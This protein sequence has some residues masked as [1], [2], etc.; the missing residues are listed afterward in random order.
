VGFTEYRVALFAAY[1]AVVVWKYSKHT[2][3]NLWI[4]LIGWFVLRFLIWV[5]E[6]GQ[7]RWRERQAVRAVR[8][9]DPAHQEAL[10]SKM[11]LSVDRRF[12]RKRLAAEGTPERADAVERFFF[13]ASDHRENVLLFWVTA[14]V[15]MGLL[16]VLYTLRDLPTWA[17]C[18][19][20]VIT[21]I[22]MIVLAWL[23]RRERHLATVLE[24]SPF[25][26]SEVTPDGTRRTIQWSQAL[27]LW[28]RPRLRRAQL[29]VAGRADF[30]ALDYSRLA[31]ERIANLVLDYGK[32]RREGAS[33]A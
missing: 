20:W 19:L 26:I 33:A 32:F 23:R 3:G 4:Y 17:A 22:L 31:F 11:W 24:I 14:V 15:C 21:V 6:H 10:I 13:G 27:V 25:A 18:S 5:A 7:W 16:T 2:E 28:N 1:L 12:Y 9:L 30:V 29:H 8:S